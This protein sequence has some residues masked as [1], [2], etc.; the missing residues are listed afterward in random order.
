MILT[1]MSLGFLSKKNNSICINLYCYEKKLTFLIQISDQ[2]FESLMDLLLVIDEKKNH[3]ICI[4]KILTDLCFKKQ[5]IKTKD[6][7]ARVV[8]YVLVVKMY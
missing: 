4:S 8:C 7:F 6:T 5:K 1:M 3:I 2:E